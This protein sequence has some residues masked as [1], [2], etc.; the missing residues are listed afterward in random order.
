M[1]TDE[2]AEPQS[3]LARDNIYHRLRAE[4]LSRRLLPGQLLQERDLAARFSLSKSPIRD[5][6]LRLA[7]QGLIEVLPRKGYRVSRI[8]VSD[9]RDMY[10][11]RQ[12]L[13]RECVTRFIETADSGLLAGLE[14]FRIGPAEPDLAHWIDYNRGFHSYIAAHCGNARL[15]RLACD[16]IEQFDRFTYIGVTSSADL[17]LATFVVEHGEIIDAIAA[18][19]KRLATSLSRKHIQNSSR[20]V[21]SSL[22]ASSVV[23]TSPAQR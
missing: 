5:A 14:V 2:S 23:D 17:S 9:V 4:V 16:M 3:P 7:E 19:N 12:M 20:R 11:L 15:A 13:E 1:Q 8:D 10:G 21:L 6:L 18:R 22:A